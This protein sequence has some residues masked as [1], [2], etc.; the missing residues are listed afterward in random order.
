[1]E[2]VGIIGYGNMGKAIA[3]RI[4]EKYAV[5]V[6]D[7]DKN[8]TS[9][10]KD[11]TAVNLP[12][13]LVKQS[14]IIILAV[15][16]QDFEVMLKEIKPFADDKLFI[17]IAAG[18]T[19]G[20]INSQLGSKARIVRIMPNMPAQIGRAVSVISKGQN[21]T[22]GDFNL[23]WQLAFDIF[24][25]LG[26]VLPVDKE[27]MINAAT[28]ISGSG[29]AFFCYYIKESKNA[30]SQRDEFIKV[31]ADAA[32]NLGFDQREAELLAAG[33][34]D[35]TIAMLNERNLSCAEVIKMVA[36]KG[37][38]TEAGLEILRAGGSLKEATEKAAR[39]A[40]ELEKRS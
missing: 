24:S 20:Y 15:K 36:S 13:D 21:A 23:V 9:A 2:R 14:E 35:G 4:K 22:E 1:M 34:V 19:S 16:P 28:A 29:P 7:K 6:F 31:L 37:G 5:C 39:R 32:V 11:I 3:E 38:T 26:S 40:G 33:T 27:E 30:S 8:K 17:T 18:I 25:N 12:G 10:L